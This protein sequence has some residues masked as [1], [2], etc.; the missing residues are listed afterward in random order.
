MRGVTYHAH[1]I[2]TALFF[3][4]HDYLADATDVQRL[5]AEL[6]ADKIVHTKQSS[7]YAHLDYTWAV[8]ANTEVYSDI[9]AL[10]KARL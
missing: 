5:L 3:G 1:Q 7:T 8:N 10:L 6:P 4:D 9:L 2:P